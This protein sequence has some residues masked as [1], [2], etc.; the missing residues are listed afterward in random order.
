MNNSG[1]AILCHYYIHQNTEISFHLTSAVEINKL[2]YEKKS[3]IFSRNCVLKLPEPHH[4]PVTGLF[5]SPHKSVPIFSSWESWRKS[6][7][8]KALLWPSLGWKVLATCQLF[9]AVSLDGGAMGDLF[10]F[11]L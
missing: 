5:P 9:T 11:S 10:L 1:K 3:S 7:R 2:V 6:V 4:D 8:K